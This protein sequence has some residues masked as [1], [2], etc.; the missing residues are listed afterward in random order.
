MAETTKGSKAQVTDDLQRTVDRHQTEI[1]L[2]RRDLGEL[3]ES[4]RHVGGTLK[5]ISESITEIKLTAPT[6]WKNTLP[7]IVALIVIFTAMASGIT[8]VASN[9]SAQK[10]HEMDKRLLMLELIIRARQ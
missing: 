2:I 4:V 9:S 10:F 5:E 7:S 1:Q 6:P 8:Y 3:A